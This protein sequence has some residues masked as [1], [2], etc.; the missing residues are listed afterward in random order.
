MGVTRERVRQ[1]EAQALSRLSIR[2]YGESCVTI[3]KSK[4]KLNYYSST[5]Y[6]S[7]EF[8]LTTH[9]YNDEMR[10]GVLVMNIVAAFQD[11]RKVFLVLVF[12][13]VFFIMLGPPQDADMWWHLRAGKEMVE[14][15]KI[16]TT[17]IFSYTHYG[18]SWTNAFWLSDIMLYLAYGLG[19]YLGIALLV[20]FTSILTMAVI[21]RHTAANPF[22]LPLLIILLAAFAIAP[23]WTPRPQIFSFLLL[24]ILDYGLSGRNGFILK[25][26]GLIVPIFI[27]WANLHG[28]FIWGFLLLVAFI[29][30]TGIDNLLSR[31]NSL[32]LKQLRNLG[33][34]H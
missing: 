29:V 13:L 15:E 19:G 30:G 12:L 10:P 27:L 16:L 5:G 3:W 22:P 7:S 31:E 23:V 11:L 17:D 1:I 18:E 14:Q 8:V 28:G 25:R 21:Y 26:P 6:R 2:R 4:R 34:G 24:A 9:V 20:S 32:S 33:C